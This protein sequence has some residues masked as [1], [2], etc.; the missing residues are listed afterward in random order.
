[1][2]PYGIVNTGDRADLVAKNSC[3]VL[4]CIRL[5]CDYEA[6]RAERFSDEG[7]K[8]GPQPLSDRLR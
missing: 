4:L 3:D 2:A 8:D 1:M 5:E 7:V 6:I